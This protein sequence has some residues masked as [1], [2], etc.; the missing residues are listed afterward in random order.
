MR[1]FYRVDLDSVVETRS[2]GW[3]LSPVHGESPVIDCC[4]SGSP[5]NPWQVKLNAL[6][7][8]DEGREEIVVPFSE[9]VGVCPNCGVV[10]SD[11]A[12]FIESGSNPSCHLC[13][14]TGYA[15][16][17]VMVRCEHKCFT[18]SQQLNRSHLHD[19]L[20]RTGRGQLVYS[21][22]LRGWFEC[23]EWVERGLFPETS[24]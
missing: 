2:I 3:S 22:V 19:D 5:D 10:V 4:Q 12:E 21:F 1:Y 9:D 16:R 11:D 17:V 14:G 13:G 18:S 20:L 8:A 7:D 6:K 15:H 23:G 24:F